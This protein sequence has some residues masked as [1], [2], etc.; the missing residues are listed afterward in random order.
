MRCCNDELGERQMYACKCVGR[1]GGCGLE[2]W[3][4]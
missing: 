2:V 3:S 4:T 1:V